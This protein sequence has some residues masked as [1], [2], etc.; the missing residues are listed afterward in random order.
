M[1]VD[2][3]S[4]LRQSNTLYLQ[5]LLKTRE[6]DQLF[7]NKSVINKEV[8]SIN[9][10]ELL[11][12]TRSNH[13]VASLDVAPNKEVIAQK[14]TPPINTTQS[15]PYSSFIQ[16]ILPIAKKAAS[17]IGL[18][19]KL[20][21]AEVI[22]E[23]GWGKFVSANNVFNIKTGNSKAYDSVPLKTT[24]YFNHVAVKT[25]ENFRSYASVEQSFH[26]YISLIQNDTR[27]KEALAHTHNPER[28]VAELSKAGYATDPEYGK[29]ILSIYKMI[30]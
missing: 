24:E 12:D 28:Y 25:T 18:D 11:E 27:Y 23:T 10:Q 1:L 6:M 22:L 26:D 3:V 14:V 17:L 29:K 4:A 9:F 8:D 15:T 20:L 21:I 19:P 30:A 16:S 5:C 13:S 7:S 2:N